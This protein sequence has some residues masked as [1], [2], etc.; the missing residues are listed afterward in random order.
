MKKIS[1]FAV[2]LLS[3][4]AGFSQSKNETGDLKLDKKQQE[5]W[6]K[7]IDL[8]NA[9]FGSKNA[10]VI[11][12]LVGEGLNYVHSGGNM[13]D[14]ATMIKNASKSTTVYENVTNQ[15]VSIKMIGNVA[16]L[17]VILKATSLEKGGSSALNLGILQVWNKV[18]GKWKLIE[19]QA[20]KRSVP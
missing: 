7:V 6:N 15:L 8:H 4:L 13:E 19:R 12:S 20:V 17:R 3:V 5:V 2:L 14:R 11:G 18:G 10:D 9:V 16:I 1:M